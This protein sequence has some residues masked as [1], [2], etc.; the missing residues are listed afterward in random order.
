[1][2]G[3]RS[4]T[5]LA[6]LLREAGCSRAWLARQVNYLAGRQGLVMRY[7]KVS[8]TR[9]LQ[10]MHPRGR[11]PEFV[12]AALA[13]RL[14][15]SVT[16]AQLGFHVE[17]Q[18]P[19]VTR[20]LAYREDVNET[21]HTLAELG[22]T[23]ISR[24]DLLGGVP[25]VA[26]ALLDPQRQ[27][28]LWLVDHGEPDVLR[29]VAKSPHAEQVHAMIAMFDTM[30]NRF[31]GRGV[32][33][34]IVHYL[35]SEVIPLLQDQ[36]VPATERRKLFTGAAKL[37][38]M[39]GWSSYDSAEYGLAQRYMTQGLRL[40]AEGG[41]RVLG[42]QILAGLSH[43]AT[44]LGRPDEGVSLARAGVAAARGAGSPTGLMR[45]HAMV[46]RGYAALNQRR[47][48]MTALR[49]AEAALES[50]RGPE[51]ESEWVRYLDFHYLEAEAACCFRDLGD[52]AQA[53]RYAGA[54]VLA[55]GDRRR[56]QAIS[57]SVL[58]TAHLQQ[59]RLDEAVSN[60]STALD[61]LTGVRSERSVQSLRD[62]RARLEPLRAEPVVQDFEKRARPV[63]GVAA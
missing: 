20:A 31:G 60:A 1:M 44:N 27:W 35:S 7:D 39:A 46:A 28:L 3:E 55:N 36:T 51:N 47:E 49:A 38:A 2:S 42:G 37:A 15:R 6:A 45:L 63:L 57:Q 17:R 29:A 12:A 59:G 41:D 34:S 13:G 22:S 24:R 33:T 56:R 40:C 5:A 62:F 19:I 50:S 58:A 25:F 32:R 4:N 21:L 11:A 26:S 23:D 43:L 10:G 61:L 14:S 54:S 8:V 16:P 18:R 9:W 53:E 48:A 30:D 52:S